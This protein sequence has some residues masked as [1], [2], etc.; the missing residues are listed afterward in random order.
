MAQWVKKSPV[1]AG[2]ECWIHGLGRS[3]G[4]GN[5]NPHQY[6]CLGNPM[7]KGS[8][9]SYNLWGTKELDLTYKLNKNNKNS[10]NSPS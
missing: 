8:L 9:A 4:E 3:S 6:S 7:N 1:H 10:G 2:D 5:G